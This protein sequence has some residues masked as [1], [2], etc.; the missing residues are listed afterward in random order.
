[1]A[2]GAPRQHLGKHFWIIFSEPVENA[3]DRRA[4]HH[5]HLAHQYDLEA[6][7]IMFAAGPFLGDDG[8]PSGPGMIIIRARDEVAAREIADRDPYHKL[9]F[10][11]YRLQRW[12][13]NEGT[14]GLRVN[15][16]N[17]TYTID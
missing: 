3:G 6:R 1:M 10:R 4:A 16:S 11:K 14:F 2:D 8:K 15:F 9:G 7:G 13:M 5:L 17:G 12:A